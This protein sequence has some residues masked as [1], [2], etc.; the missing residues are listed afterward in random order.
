MPEY[1]YGECNI[2]DFREL[3]DFSRKELE[4]VVEMFRSTNECF[5]SGENLDTLLKDLCYFSSVFCGEK[6]GQIF[7]DWT[8][9]ED[10]FYLDEPD[11]SNMRSEDIVEHERIEM[12]PKVCRRSLVYRTLRDINIP[13]KLDVFWRDFTSKIDN[14]LNEIGPSVH[15]SVC[16]D[17][18]DLSKSLDYSRGLSIRDAEWNCQPEYGQFLGIP[19]D[20]IIDNP[21]E[22]VSIEPPDWLSS[23]RKFYISLVPY[24][25][26]NNSDEIGRAVDIGRDYFNCLLKFSRVVDLEDE[27]MRYKKD[28]TEE[29]TN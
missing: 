19:E 12:K 27:V 6:T 16:Q 3:D 13:F 29:N 10:L 4:K 22:D 2:G 11:S 26:R 21:E 5:D 18:D 8:L 23:E 7:V 9:D 28:W 20:D 14:G 1:I 17:R 25:F 15:Y 24:A